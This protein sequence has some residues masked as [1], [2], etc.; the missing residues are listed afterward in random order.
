MWS[1]Q[2]HVN[3][4]VFCNKV[5]EDAH[6]YGEKI[7]SR[8]LVTSVNFCVVSFKLE[9]LTTIEGKLIVLIII[10][11]IVLEYHLQTL[12]MEAHSGC[13]LVLFKWDSMS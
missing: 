3:V 13:I 4:G 11:L 9:R 5:D 6:K 7:L 1:E 8:S 2:I 10:T 12:R